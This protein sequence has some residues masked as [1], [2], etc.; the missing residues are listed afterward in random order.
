MCI[1]VLPE[2]QAMRQSTYAWLVEHRFAGWI[3]KAFGD[4]DPVYLLQDHERCLWASAP[5]E[6]MKAHHSGPWRDVRSCEGRRGD[7]TSARCLSRARRTRT[8]ESQ[9]LNPIEEVWRE[10]KGRLQDTEPTSR[11]TRAKFIC[12]LR[13]AI[14]WVRRNRSDALHYRRDTAL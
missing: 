7:D 14:A 3:S 12:R 5:R 9:D 8:P 1:Y 10:V 13:H 11:E 2:G 6:E 4:D